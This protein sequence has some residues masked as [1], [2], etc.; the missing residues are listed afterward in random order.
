MCDTS[1]A[2]SAT[3]RCSYSRVTSTTSPSIASQKPP[4]TRVRRLGRAPPA[5]SATTSRGSRHSASWIDHLSLLTLHPPGACV[6]PARRPVVR[7]RLGAVPL[8][9]E[10]RHLEQ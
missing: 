1:P 4:R 10:D 8:G 9:C 7:R 6:E 3:T 5:Q 2:E